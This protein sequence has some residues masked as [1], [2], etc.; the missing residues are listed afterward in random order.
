MVKSR[1]LRLAKHVARI[2]NYNARNA[3]Y[4]V[5]V[6]KPEDKRP[7]WRLGIPGSKIVEYLKG[8]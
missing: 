5:L 1:R 6:G 7:F 3:S 4:N 2:I 8:K